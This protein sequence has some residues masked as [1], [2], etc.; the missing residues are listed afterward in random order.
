MCVE[1]LK[2]TGQYKKALIECFERAKTEKDVVCVGIGIKL[3]IDGKD[4]SKLM[5]IPKGLLDYELNRILKVYDDDLCLKINK[6]IKIE[7]I[8]GTKD[9][10]IQ[11]SAFF[12]LFGE[13]EFV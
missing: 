2:A 11:C 5:I 6:N 4:Y 9:V 13:L 8:T 1:K 3:N 7:Y 12:Q 10:D